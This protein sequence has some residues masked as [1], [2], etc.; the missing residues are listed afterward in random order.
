MCVYIQL[1][2]SIRSLGGIKRQWLKLWEPLLPSPRT[3][4]SKTLYPSLCYFSINLRS[5]SGTLCRLKECFCIGS[6]VR[7]IIIKLQPFSLLFLFIFF[8]YRYSMWV[9][10]IVTTIL[11]IKEAAHYINIMHYS[12]GNNDIVMCPA[13]L[14]LWDYLSY[15]CK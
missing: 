5:L 7:F 14:G 2:D 8:L 10:C 3:K 4:S 1:P 9:C 6:D 15:F 13:F 12:V 11:S